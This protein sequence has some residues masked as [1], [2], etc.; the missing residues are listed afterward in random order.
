[1]NNINNINETVWTKL[2]E[3]DLILVGIGEEM[4]AD[5]RRM[6]MERLYK[7]FPDIIA[8]DIE[9]KWMIPYLEKVF[10]E[11]YKEA[12][13]MKAYASL[14]EMLKG[15]NYFIIS[16]SIDD[17]IYTTNL[18]KEK[19]VTPCGGYRLQQCTGN[20]SSRLTKPDDSILGQIRA[21]LHKKGKL[22]SLVKPLCEKCG[23]E[24]V[25]NNIKAE[26]YNEEGYL[27]QW[28]RYTKWLQG[29]VNRRICILE[30]GVGMKFPTVIRWP[31]EKIVFF[32]NK[33]SL[34]RIH[35]KLY[36]LS[37]E[38]RDKSYSV[39]QNPIDFLHNF[40]YNRFV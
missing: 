20:C 19:I 28:N 18:N 15:K 23:G 26:A 37:E 31:F 1:M 2:K 27:E 9:K 7:D 33:A 11:D 30:L 32:N 34:F 5:L 22:E 17:Y 25:F 29:T 36:Q 14:E 40:L 35:S 10:L 12:G 39:K 13:I 6:S 3:A 16:T 8:E 38:I 24:M 21:C 4:E